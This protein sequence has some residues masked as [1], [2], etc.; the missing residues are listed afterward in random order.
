V[1]ERGGR[2]RGIE[3]EKRGRRG[4]ERERRVIVLM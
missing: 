1:I 4:K 3:R 2:K